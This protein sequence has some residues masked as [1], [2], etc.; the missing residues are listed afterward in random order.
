MGAQDCPRRIAR[1]PSSFLDYPSHKVLLGDVTN[2]KAALED[3]DRVLGYDGPPA[4][5]YIVVEETQGGIPGL[6][7]LP[8]GF[9]HAVL[10]YCLPG[11]VQR[12][13]NITKSGRLCELWESPAD[14]I[15]GSGGGKHGM[16]ARQMYSIRIQEWDE[17]SMMAMHHF[18]VAINASKVIYEQC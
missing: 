9:G 10:R 7:F 18:L 1:L 13:A 8:V 12:I 11:G 5:E 17:S 4:L 15:F 16:F 14:Y 6:P 2:K 3:I